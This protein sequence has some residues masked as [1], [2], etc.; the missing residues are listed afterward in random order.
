LAQLEEPLSRSSVCTECFGELSLLS[1]SLTLSISS[2]G[3]HV[4][5]LMVHG[6]GFCKE[7]WLPVIDDCIRGLRSLPA[8]PP[9][10]RSVQF[11]AL[12]LPCHGDSQPISSPLDWWKFGEVIL[13]VVHKQG[14]RKQHSVMIGVGHSLGGAVLLMAQVL[15]PGT[16]DRLLVIEPIIN[17]PSEYQTPAKELS[18]RARRRLN[19][20]SSPEVARKYFTSRALY[21]NWETRV[22]DAWIRYGL[23]EE[24]AADGRTVLKLKCDPVHEAELFFRSCYHDL[25]DHLKKV[26][27][28]TRL[29]FSAGYRS[30]L[31]Y[32]QSNF[33]QD[34]LTCREIANA[35]HSLPMERPEIIAAEVLKVLQP[36]RPRL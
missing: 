26:M 1:R 6:N 19:E 35:T 2:S 30:K 5:V 27:V 7:L 21:R 16:F 20:F 11:V 18:D 28:P 36:E 10:P 8:A 22:V 15:K 14:Y 31:A 4:V 33:N 17:T 25:H 3:P 24:A 32:V 23:R 29:L 9:P 12:D 34:V 13:E